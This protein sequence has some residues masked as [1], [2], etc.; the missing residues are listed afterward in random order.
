MTPIAVDDFRPKFPPRTTMARKAADAAIGATKAALIDKGCE[1]RRVVRR[2]GAPTPTPAPAPSAETCPPR[3]KYSARVMLVRLVST[4]LLL[5]AEDLLEGRSR[6]RPEPGVAFPSGGGS[7]SSA[8]HSPARV[9]TPV[10][11]HRWAGRSFLSFGAVL[12]GYARSGVP[13][14]HA[15]SV[16]DRVHTVD[17][18]LTCLYR[19]AAI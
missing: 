4:R 6:R 3:D 19:R 11:G 13:V 8:S 14:P 10:G 5:M 15:L 17:I 9:A 1:H 16:T 2:V 12:P 7:D 18:F